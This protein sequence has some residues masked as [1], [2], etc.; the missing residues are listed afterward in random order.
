M[1]ACKS[2]EYVP[3]DIPSFVA[4]RPERPIL[5]TGDG[6]EAKDRNILKLMIYGRE[7]EAYGDGVEAFLNDLRGEK[8]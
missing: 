4:V 2:V 5:E 3:V 6:I 8:K 1:T 7:W